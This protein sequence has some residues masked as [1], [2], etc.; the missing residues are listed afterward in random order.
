MDDGHDGLDSAQL[1]VL[2]MGLLG[3]VAVAGAVDVWLDRPEHWFTPHILVELGLMTVSG[4]TALF[5][6]RGWRRT[7]LSLAG[8]RRSLAER[9]AERD[10][11]RARAEA[12]LEGLARAIDEQCA[13]WGLTPTEREVALALLKSHGHK[14][15]A[16]ATG[17][18]ERTARQHAVAVYEKSGLGGRAELAAFFLDGLR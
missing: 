9:E 6:A 4:G 17:R 11:W 16:A 10:A 15:I 2:V 3:I 12:A 14:Q 1:R 7:Q 18:S 8:T 13:A 5:L